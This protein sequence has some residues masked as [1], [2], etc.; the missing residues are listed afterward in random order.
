[1]MEDETQQNSAPEVLLFL[2]AIAGVLCYLIWSS[3][4]NPVLD[5]PAP[6]KPKETRTYDPNAVCFGGPWAIETRTR[7]DDR[8]HK[9]GGR[10]GSITY[11]HV[12]CLPR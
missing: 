5:K 7:P 12:V 9:Q 10:G 1:M 11:Y 8:P 6:E 3:V 4:N 2:L